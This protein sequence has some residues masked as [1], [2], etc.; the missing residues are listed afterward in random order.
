MFWGGGGDDCGCDDNGDDSCGC[1]GGVEV[2]T[3][4][5]MAME[6]MAV[7]VMVQTRKKLKNYTKGT[8]IDRNK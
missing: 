2:T 4:G 3:V 8:I 7:D 5:V 6:I 1:S